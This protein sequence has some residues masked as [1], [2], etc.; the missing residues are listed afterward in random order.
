MKPEQ[1]KA[2]ESLNSKFEK[3]HT[4]LLLKKE[5]ALADELSKV[6]WE[7]QSRSYNAGMD[8]VKDLYNL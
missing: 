5:Y 2:I 8:F 6:Y 1:R 3:L 7:A 4:T